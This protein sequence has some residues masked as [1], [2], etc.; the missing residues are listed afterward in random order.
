MPGRL[1]LRTL[2]GC[3]LL[4]LLAVWLDRHALAALAW[5]PANAWLA[6]MLCRLP[7][8]RSLPVL[9][10]GLAGCQWIGGLGSG[11][12][13]AVMSILEVLSTI[14]LLRHFDL[15]SRF[16]AGAMQMVL[17]LS[18][19][20]ILPAMLGGVAGAVV[21]TWGYGEGFAAQAL[22]FGQG[23]ML[24]A[25]TALPLALWL[26][27][28]NQLR[29]PG[30]PAILHFGGGLLLVTLLDWLALRLLSSPFEVIIAVEVLASLLLSLNELFIL[31]WLQTLLM[32][33]ALASG[34]YLPPPVLTE[35]DQAM[36]ALP[37]LLT[38]LPAL[39]MAAA[40]WQRQQEQRLLSAA[41]LRLDT[42]LESMNEG[43][44][45]QAAN[46]HIVGH[47]RRALE[48]LGLEES[49]L[50]G[51]SS[52][53]PAWHCIHED[54]RP[55][56][57]GDHPAM[58]VLEHGVAIERVIMGV[59]LPSG[60]TR[61]I[62]I[63]AH[64]M[65]EPS[66]GECMCV[67]TFSDISSERETALRLRAMQARYVGLVFNAPDAIITVDSQQ[68]IVSANPA[69]GQLFGYSTAD[70][71]GQPLSILMATDSHERHTRLFERFASEE[72]YGRSMAGG[73]KVRAKRSDGSHFPLE[74]TLATVSLPEGKYF[75]AIGRDVTQ[76]EAYEQTLLELSQAIGQSPVGFVMIDRDGQI[77]Y[78]NRAY[79]QLTG[80]PNAE[81]KEMALQA[82]WQSAD[83]GTVS[84][85]PWRNAE[86]GQPWQ[87]EV[88]QKRPDGREYQVFYVISPL[89]DAEGLVGKYVGVAQDV[90]DSKR[91]SAE[92]EAHRHHLEALVEERTRDLLEAK[93][94]AESATR[95]KSTFLAN[96]SHEIRTPL[97]AI[98]GFA[99]LVRNQEQNPRAQAWLDKIDSAAQH[100]LAIINDVLDF[101]K[102]E[103]G[104]VEIHSEPFSLQPLLEFIRDMVMPRLADKP[105]S[106][107]IRVEGT[108]PANWLGDSLR[109]GQILGNF[110]SNAAKFTA[111][112]R[113][114]LVVREEGREGE[115]VWLRFEVLDSGIGI[116]PAQ[117]AR[118][119][120]P[121]VQAD[122]SI[123]RRFGGT[124]LGLA[125]SRSLAQLMG[126]SVGG[127]SRPGGG[128][129]FWLTLP[130]RPMETPQAEAVLAE[131]TGDL[132]VPLRFAGHVLIAEDNPL[133]QDFMQGLMQD[134]GLSCKVVGDGQSAV[135][136][137][138]D[139]S[140]DL[141]LMDM[142]MPVMDGLSA[143]REL[144]QFAQ[145]R[146]LPILALTANAYAED[147]DACL[148]AGMNDFLSKP[149]EPLVLRERLARY[150][151]AAA[152]SDAERIALPEAPAALFG[153]LGQR[154]QQAG[155]VDFAY[156]EKMTKGNP[157]TI[158]RVLGMFLQHHVPLAA[159]LPALL[160][161]GDLSAATRIV[162]TLK[163]TGMSLGADALRLA[164]ER[165][166]GVLRGD[167]PA[168]ADCR[169]L[170]H[171][172]ARLERVLLGPQAAEDGEA[173]EQRLRHRLQTHDVE[174]AA[175]LA[176]QRAAFLWMHEEDF[177][178]LLRLVDSFEFGPA[179][180]FFDQRSLAAKEAP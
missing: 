30:M 117:F 55:F 23:H 46:G 90:T 5:W 156:L 57:G 36:S 100:L 74:V 122:A 32:S 168:Q 105:V 19:G 35:A 103:A 165:L 62:E 26:S 92:L 135:A 153:P 171:E 61:W 126:G 132:P 109:I 127:E 82:L 24:G 114:E 25:L 174:S 7:W 21:S 177:Q 58:Q 70:L 180:R 99:H 20:A 60:D 142:Q 54:G 53:D 119:F 12:P 65:Q 111:E 14:A 148:Q 56:P 51:R 120:V 173:A 83:Q 18:V 93:E 149:I 52:L 140:F 144:R 85:M 33:W 97:N 169:A 107:E 154:L 138:L 43:I 59:N 42:V 129:C 145:T 80:L 37:L 116:D 170:C 163:G 161:G 101:S 151:P 176:Q 179:L 72:V 164:A 40:A 1:E 162:H 4:A 3:W 63:N 73:R 112:G 10:L 124:G 152:A 64:P 49:Q 50:L 6:G 77:E 86:G 157:D 48:I 143:T 22:L 110:V 102:L 118:L 146:H 131:E 66:S 98:V 167:T 125:L 155:L 133:N 134:L 71:I 8:R 123:T 38:P 128:S 141:V 94:A 95:L 121:F 76:R 29:G 2:A 17:T 67:C 78:A 130:L 137:C 39:I 175:W 178:Y 88:S 147:R 84:A 41:K 91:T 13:A 89:F 158:E 44:V 9:L 15:P 69:A 139:E 96:M 27:Q 108:V 113:I 45:I 75:M 16:H 87:G 166:E 68:T 104:H 150:L 160:A 47:N 11:L 159:G 136:A 31:L 79:E 28:P 106:F 172:V 81:L 34:L 115:L